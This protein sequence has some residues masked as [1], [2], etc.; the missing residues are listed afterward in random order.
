MQCWRYLLFGAK[1]SLVAELKGKV[2]EVCS[3]RTMHAVEVDA[4]GNVPTPSAFD[5]G[6]NVEP[7]AA[8]MHL[9]EHG[10]AGRQ[11]QTNNEGAPYCSV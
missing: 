6:R 3:S 2:R 1:S 5:P 4:I 9:C 7:S 10:S 11:K 8:A